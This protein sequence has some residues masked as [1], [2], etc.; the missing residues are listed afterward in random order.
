MIIAL[1]VLWAGTDFVVVMN[2]GEYHAR[3]VYT[4]LLDKSLFA[5][6]SYR[7]LVL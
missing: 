6:C 4:V 3:G 7:L 2:F 1:Q 5:L